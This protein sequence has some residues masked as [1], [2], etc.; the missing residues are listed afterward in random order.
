MKGITF[1]AAFA[2]AALAAGTAS[3]IEL[4]VSGEFVEATLVAKNVDDRSIT[5]RLGDDSS[6]TTFRVV[7]GARFLEMS[8]NLNRPMRMEDLRVGADLYLELGEAQ[9]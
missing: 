1:T 7:E 8:D 5:V 6:V 2:A 9:Q 4:P 3:A